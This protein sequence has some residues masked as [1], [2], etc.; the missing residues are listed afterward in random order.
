MVKIKDFTLAS[1]KTGEGALAPPV[2]Y[3]P[4]AHVISLNDKII[5]EILIY[6]VIVF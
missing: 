5:N 6:K 4:P 3:T 1:K 2:P